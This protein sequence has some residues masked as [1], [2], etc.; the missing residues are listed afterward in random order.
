MKHILLVNACLIGD[1]NGTGNT[2]AS[3]FKSVPQSSVY[4]L[5]IDFLRDPVD[6]KHCIF[7]DKFFSFSRYFLAKRR[8]NKQQS[9]D[10][11][12]HRANISG[13]R[14]SGFKAILHEF[15]RGLA[16]VL[17]VRI[18]KKMSKFIK[19]CKPDYIYTCG[20]S[21]TSLKTSRKISGKFNIPLVLHIMDNWEETLYSSSVL[22][23]PFSFLLKRE[24]SKAN[25]CSNQSLAVSQ[26]LC[27]KF[28]EKYNVNYLPLMNTVDEINNEP[29]CFSREKLVFMYAGSLSINRY[30]SLAQIAEVLHSVLGEDGYIFK[31]FVPSSQNTEDIKSY[32]KGYNVLF[33]DYV[34]RQQ[35]FREY[36][37]AD[38]LVISESFDKNFCDFTKYSLSTKVPEYMACG[39]PVLAF[40]SKTLYSYKYLKSSD[41]AL[42][43]DSKEK[44]TK[45]IGEI[46]DYDKRYSLASCGLDF[47]K[48]YHSR[49]YCNNVL[50]EIFK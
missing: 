38:V 9:E 2:L 5:C 8:K 16:D 43:A 21:I 28:S 24:L 48:K 36:A 25:K 27:N 47:V 14:A 3:V 35:L 44:L 12:K 7:V 13:A 26:I 1:N 19:E 49:D 39:K 30:V 11:A 33:S 45:A 41:A 46:K 4:Q 50:S 29:L 10:A 20:S 23:K 34:P 31:L 18:S 17:P 6:N 40:L 37:D 15:F 22:T 32:F 42:V